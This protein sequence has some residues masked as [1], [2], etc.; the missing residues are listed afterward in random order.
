MFDHFNRVL[1]FIHKDIDSCAIVVV[2]DVMLDQYYFSDVQRI[3][4]EAPVPIA[5]VIREKATLG[6]AANVAH[7]LALLGC[8]VL[9]GGAVGHDNNQRKLMQLLT[10]KG[11]DG[12]GL[13]RGTQS[14]ITKMR[15]IGASQQMLRLD[16]EENGPIS[17]T[18]LEELKDWYTSSLAQ[19]DA[20]IISDYAKGVC[21]PELCMH[22]IALAAERNIPVVIDPKGDNWEKYSGA[23]YITPNLK[24]LC[25]V[26]QAK[27]A[28]VDDE[29]CIYAKKIIQ[30]Y[31]IANVVVT[32][33]ERG[34]SIVNSDVVHIPTL[35][36]EVFDV[37]GAGDTVAA[38]LGAGIAGKLNSIDA[39]RLANLA[40]GVVV[41]RVG[42][43]A[44]SKAELLTAIRQYSRES[45]LARKILIS[46][47]EASQV[48]D[49]WRAQGFEIVFTNGCFDILHAGHVIYLE[50]AKKLGTKL[51]VALNSDVSV[52][53]LKG[54]ER[55]VVS[56]Q[57]RVKIIAA[58]ECVDAVVL[59]EQD[60]PAEL[61]KTLKPDI[62][63]KG[64]DYTPDMVV[65][66]ECAGRVEII[67]FEADKSTTGIIEKILVAYN[68]R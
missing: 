8:R 51:I 61:L 58:L 41:A 35:A 7:N 43:Y 17:A 65:G 28:N 24:E 54:P 37:S 46:F 16:F 13:I 9:L 56:E 57:D 53:R 10:E 55:P 44:I 31:G 49:R 48:V 67:E 63:V 25:E 18:V 50:K 47:E 22:F 30:R 5:Q 15:V 59:F 19:A 2:G 14:T 62:L 66:R 36:E 68:N 40:A 27:V 11:I 60:T 32:R 12:S 64:G 20:V 21:T 45:G 6:G 39:A 29:V 26:V 23:T 33:S 3:S 38:V 1:E 4:P 52:R 42:T 34:L